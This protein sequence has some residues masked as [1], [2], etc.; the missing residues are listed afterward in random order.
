MN[1]VHE[2]LKETYKKTKWPFFPVSPL[3][4]AFGS[5]TI[6]Q[7]NELRKEGIVRRRPHVNGT[8]VELLITE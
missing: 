7:L 2:F 1:E 5:S 3:K 6:L 4:L 8:L